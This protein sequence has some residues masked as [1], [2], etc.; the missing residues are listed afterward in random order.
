MFMIIF[1]LDH[2]MEDQIITRS[3]EEEMALVGFVVNQATPRSN[4]G[5]TRRLKIK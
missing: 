2:V 5:I 4:V 3:L 1:T